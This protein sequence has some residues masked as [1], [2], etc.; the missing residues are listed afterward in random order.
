MSD[1]ANAL[2]YPLIVPGATEEPLL[3]GRE[4]DC[5][6]MTMAAALEASA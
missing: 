5:M 4:S 2:V 6:L 3:D 1:P